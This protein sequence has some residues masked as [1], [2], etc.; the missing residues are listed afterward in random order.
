[1]RLI[2]AN[3]ERITED[4]KEI[5]ELK[6]EGYVEVKDAGKPKGKNTR[7]ATKTDSK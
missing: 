3:V 2:R 1:M 4:E 7:K 6:E 5:R